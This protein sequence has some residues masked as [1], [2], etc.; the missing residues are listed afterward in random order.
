MTAI[1]LCLML[2]LPLFSGC[3]TQG[4]G[5]ET[6]NPTEQSQPIQDGEKNMYTENNI[7]PD[8]TNSLSEQEYTLSS[9]SLQWK[10]NWK[11]GV[12][13]ISIYDTLLEHEYLTKTFSLFNYLTRENLVVGGYTSTGPYSA[14]NDSVTGAYVNE[15]G[16]KLTLEIKSEKAEALAFTAILEAADGQIHTQITVHNQADVERIVYVDYPSLTNLSIPGDPADARVMLPSEIGWVG[17]YETGNFYGNG[18]DADDAQMP[19]G[20][21]VMQVASIYNV[22]GNGGIYF[23]DRNG[24]VMSDTPALALYVAGHAVAGRWTKQLE[25]NTSAVS[26]VLTTGLIHDDDWHTAV[27]AYMAYQK[28]RLTN[29]D[30]IPAWLLE[31]GAVYSSRREG[32]GGTYQAFPEEG[33]MLTRISH[34]DEMDKM[35]EEAQSFGTDVILLV[36]YY[37]RADT[38]GLDPSLASTVRNMPYWNKG[39]YVPRSDMGGEDAFRNGIAKVHE[40]GGKVMVYVEPFIIFQYSN[41]GRTIGFRW[42]ARNVS[43]G[44][45]DSYALC[46]TMVAAYDQWQDYCVKICKELVEKYDI[47]GI[48]LDS[49][50][51]QWNR[52]YF[53]QGGK[54]IYSYEE[55]NQGMIE[56]NNRVREAIREIKPDA[57]VLSESGGGPLPAYNDGGWAAQ[58]VWGDTTQAEGILASPVRYASNVNFITN[59]NNIEELNQVFAAGFSL[60]VSDYWNNDKAYINQLV[61][62]RKD[63]CDALVY[64]KQS[65]LVTQRENV[66]AYCYTGEN[67]TIIPVVNVGKDTY[68]GTVQVPFSNATV[69][70]DILSG[71][72]YPV[73]SDGTVTISI[74]TGDL[75]VLKIK[76]G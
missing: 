28:D 37:E 35:L 12:R 53:T 50:G 27:D 25:G 18:F 26:A 54:E 9:E 57:V 24:A 56:L 34:F 60:A 52:L 49:M 47:D 32:T 61:Q 43:G 65:Q 4:R 22:G 44:L 11:D 13:I 41:I 16:T 40:K 42:G 31:A 6:Q 5:D 14:A 3:G 70:V 69:L 15:E 73:G 2:C 46:Y 30:G 67:N 19:T 55:Y 66:V 62:I 10:I 21:N 58:N 75:V 39:D 1:L 17:P 63:Y 68:T 72:S 45:D 64:G 29:K 38:T 76:E 7:K 48:L 71:D 36:D 74:D 23:L 59:G 51:W 20:W 8:Y 33:S